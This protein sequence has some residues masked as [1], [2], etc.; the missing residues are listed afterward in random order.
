MFALIWN[1]NFNHNNK[2]WRFC[3]H[4]AVIESA[5]RHGDHQFGNYQHS[6]IY[7]KTSVNILAMILIMIRHISN[8]SENELLTE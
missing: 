8:R 1:F 6:N 5:T 4:T 3:S 7:L 2:R